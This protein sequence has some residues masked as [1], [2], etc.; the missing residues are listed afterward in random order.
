MKIF[1]FKK[2]PL[3]HISYGGSVRKIGILI[4]NQ[5][6]MLKFQKRTSYGLRFNTISEYIGS[7]VFRL[8]G[9]NGQ[10]TI[11]GTYGDEIVVGSGILTRM[12]INSCLLMILRK[13]RLKMIKRN[14]SIAMKIF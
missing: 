9:M 10:D 7:H 1:D 12:V 8:L 14:I 6:Y 2:Y 4:D 5:P 11:L 3:S 13:A